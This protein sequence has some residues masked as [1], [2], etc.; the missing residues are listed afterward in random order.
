[1]AWLGKVPAQRAEAMA[2]R[3]LRQYGVEDPAH[4]RLEDI[5]WDQGMKVVL[6]GLEGAEARLTV[7]D[8]KAVIRVAG[9]DL[10]APRVRFGIAHEMGHFVVQ[11]ERLRTCTTEDLSTWT[12]DNKL[13]AQAN[14]FAACMLMPRFLLD[15]DL[16]WGITAARVRNVAE[17]YRASRRAAAIRV[18]KVA[19]RPCAVACCEDGRVRWVARGDKFP[20]V[21]SG[22]RVSRLSIAS[23]VY[24]PSRRPIGAEVVPWHAWVEDGEEARG[25]L[26]EDLLDV[27]H[28]K[29]LSILTIE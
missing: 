16:G 1:M 3:L 26:V 21:R 15:P 20:F 9:Q 24:D 18:A 10:E 17:R 5:A 2:E 25:E 4:I 8:G 11:N 22:G 14:Y 27:G 29:V 13:E 19:R 23:T 12:N 28:G 7:S 6:G